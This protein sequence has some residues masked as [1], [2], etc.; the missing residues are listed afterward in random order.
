MKRVVFSLVG[1]LICSAAVI[2][3]C[4]AIYSMGRIGTCASGG[5]YVSARPCPAG[6]AEK[7][8]LIPIAIVAAL[9]GIG[10]YSAGGLSN[11]RPSPVSL[12]L[13]MWSFTF[14][15][16][17]GSL[18]Y[19][20]YG[21]AATQDDTGQKAAAII[22][23]V[24]F[25]PMAVIPLLIALFRGLGQRR[26][27]SISAAGAAA[28]YAAW[29]GGATSSSSSAFGT[30]TPSSTPAAPLAPRPTPPATHAAA[31]GEDVVAR[32]EQLNALRESGA[33]TPEEFARLKAKVL[34]DS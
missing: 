11:H 27:P 31:G 19:A 21:P 28:N 17:A 8:V 10:I 32:L 15:G 3:F 24:I 5:P 6:T 1:L 22:L 13:L 33:I 20:A 18:A 29:S 14:L 25:I 7:I 34:S 30:S 26:S 2:A 23:L 12:G 4:Y 16:A 9:V